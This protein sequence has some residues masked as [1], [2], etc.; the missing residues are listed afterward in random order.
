MIIAEEHAGSRPERST[1]QQ[2]FNFRI[3]CD[4][5]LQHQQD[6]YH[7]FVDFKKACDKVWHAALWATT[8]QYNINANLIRMTPNLYN[9]P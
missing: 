5:Y 2:I 1:T 4:E 9:K 6:L 3:L 8:R 7:D